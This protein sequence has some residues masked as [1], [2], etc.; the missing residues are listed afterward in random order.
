MLPSAG[1][2][3]IHKADSELMLF[4]VV[5]VAVVYFC[6]VFA[7]SCHVAQAGLELLILLPP[8]PKCIT[9]LNVNKSYPLP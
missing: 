8:F 5:V 7:E 4:F 9:S 3:S 6:F 1:L 2:S